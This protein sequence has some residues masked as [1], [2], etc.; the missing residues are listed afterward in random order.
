MSIYCGKCDREAGLSADLIEYECAGPVGCGNRA[1]RDFND[2]SRWPFYFEKKAVESVE[3][4]VESNDPKLRTENPE[5]RE[6]TMKKSGGYRKSEY[7]QEEMIRTGMEIR[8]MRK[9]AGISQENLGA[10]VG[11]TGTAI[12]SFER[13][14][15]LTKAAVDAIMNYFAPE[16][17]DGRGK[18]EEGSEK[19][20]VSDQH[21]AISA[22]PPPK[23]FLT[24]MVR[25]LAQMNETLARIEQE[26]KVPRNFSINL[27]AVTNG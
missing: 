18:M 27:R 19:A 12:S 8:A 4:K 24:E 2:T 5:T 1:M 17:A 3:R 21:S 20:A 23:G 7:T 14:H 16:D 22:A 25:L 26:M 9:A 15:Y 13:G 6:S 11:Y 10:A